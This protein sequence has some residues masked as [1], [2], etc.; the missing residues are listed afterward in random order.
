MD[1]AAEEKKI[2]TK[3]SLRY[4]EEYDQFRVFNVT[5]EFQ[6]YVGN[7]L[8]K[9]M[10]Q[11]LSENLVECSE[12]RRKR[13]KI[14]NCVKL[15]SSSK[16]PMDI[17]CDNFENPGNTPSVRP[18][19]K[20]QKIVISESELKSIVISGEDVLNKKGTEYWSNRSKAPVYTYIKNKDG[21][22]RLKE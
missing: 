13:R 18:K 20:K 5:P 14:E 19:T 16:H 22:L 2:E 10:D 3:P 4:K 7:A 11:Y 9:K 15:L 12:K 8:S 1:D 6:K 21:T 17:D